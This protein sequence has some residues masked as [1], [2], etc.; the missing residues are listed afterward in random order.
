MRANAR[1][2]AL[3]AVIAVGISCTESPQPTGYKLN[4]YDE[5]LLGGWSRSFEEEPAQSEIEIFRRTD[6]RDFAAAMFRRRY[7]FYEDHTCEW[8]VLHPSDAHYMTSGS[9]TVDPHDRKV[10]LVY[11]ADGL[12]ENVSFRIVELTAEIL[13]VT[14]I[15]N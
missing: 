15:S 4:E 5:D 10:I 1:I 2:V 14:R 9:W 8:L 11:D 7:V 12:V 13:R 6:S 3:V